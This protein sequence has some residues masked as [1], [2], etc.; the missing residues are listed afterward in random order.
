MST[1]AYTLPVSRKAIGT[2]MLTWGPAESDPDGPKFDSI[3]AALD[4]GADMINSGAFYGLKDP[5]SNLKLLRRFFEKVRGRREVCWC[6]RD[7]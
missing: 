1:K 2:M 5:L 6:L 4:Q 7:P 3:K